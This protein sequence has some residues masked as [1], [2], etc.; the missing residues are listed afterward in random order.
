MDAIITQIRDGLDFKVTKLE[1]DKL[2]EHITYTFKQQVTRP[3]TKE[4]IMKFIAD[5]KA[6]I[7]TNR[8]LLSVDID[9]L[10]TNAET[11]LSDQKR[12]VGQSSALSSAS[13]S[14][15]VCVDSIASMLGVGSIATLRREL[16]PDSCI[17]RAYLLLDRR[18]Y[19]RIPSDNITFVW[20]ISSQS[21][22]YDVNSMCQTTTLLRRITGM[23]VLPF[24]F[25]STLNAVTEVNTISMLFQEFFAQAY[26]AN[27][28]RRRFHFL[29]DIE[30]TGSAPSDPYNLTNIG[31]NVC[32]YLFDS[33]FTDLTT[34]TLTFANP[35]RLLRLDPDQLYGTIAAVGAECKITFTEA[36][37]L[38]VGDVIIVSGYSTTSPS[39]DSV[40]IA[41]VNDPDGWATTAVTTFTATIPIDLSGLV[42]VPVGSPYLVYFESKRFTIPLEVY[43][44]SGED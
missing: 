26:V 42:G 31:Y 13:S 18:Y 43:C 12:S 22:G 39:D 29:L 41:L 24:R 3:Y 7:N 19:S 25:P 36:N 33:P 21:A 28:N 40:E 11:A 38:A 17:T 35:F 23:K 27:E 10:V 5:T 30:R 15:T 6:A 44:V 2:V 20:N 4:K 37:N 14:A 1:S 34:L 8:K 32:E 9:A 16:N